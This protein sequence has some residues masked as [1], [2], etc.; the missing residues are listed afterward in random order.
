MII[1]QRRGGGGYWPWQCP[2][3]QLVR[4]DGQ[5]VDVGG[6]PNR[7]PTELLGRR[8]GRRTGSQPQRTRVANSGRGHR[9]P[10][11]GD[12]RVALAVEQ[13]VRRLDV[14]VD[15]SPAMSEVEPCGDV[16]HGLD[17]LF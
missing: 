1:D 2:R 16:A 11:V 5:G 4:H 10:K 14:T 8:V 13:H 7:R 17:R 9:N 6:R 15:R 12:V 3:E